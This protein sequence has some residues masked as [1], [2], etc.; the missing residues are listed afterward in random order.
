MGIRTCS[1]PEVVVPVLG[2]I[3]DPRAICG[4]IERKVGERERWSFLLVVM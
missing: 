2:R 1:H 4:M 3:W